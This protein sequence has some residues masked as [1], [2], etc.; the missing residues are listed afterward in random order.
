V[1]RVRIRDS[2]TVAL[3]LA[4]SR[5]ISVAFRRVIS[6]AAGSR[7]GQRL[8][9]PHRI[10]RRLEL[11]PSGLYRDVIIIIFPNLTF[12]PP[13][14]QQ[15]ITIIMQI[16]MIRCYRPRRGAAAEEI[17]IKYYCIDITC[18]HQEK[19]P[20]KSASSSRLRSRQS[21]FPSSSQASWLP[22]TRRTLLAQTSG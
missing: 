5:M 18:S 14:I 22:N 19:L 8:L 6:Q 16:M 7:S 3:S 1:N 17:T 9:L 11:Q 4:A 13:A 15:T 12:S 2:N 20:R 10:I 21:P